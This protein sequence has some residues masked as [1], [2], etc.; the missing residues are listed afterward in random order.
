MAN[1]VRAE[2]DQLSEISG[3]F[4]SESG[5]VARRVDTI[6][7][8]METLEGGD[9]IG[10]GAQA[11][12]REMHSEVL[13]ALQRLV[14]ALAFAAKATQQ[15]SQAMKEAEEESAGIF[16][17]DPYAGDDVVDALRRAGGIAQAEVAGLGGAAQAAASAAASGAGS[18]GGG[19][20]SGA[21]S[22]G[23]SAGGGSSGGGGGSWSGEIGFRQ[24][25]PGPDSAGGR[26]RATG[27]RKR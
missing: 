15:A 26:P 5:Q 20:G 3:T 21:G 2:Y 12:F 6:R 9:W 13:P 22:E 27:R 19:G 24:E 23:G 14:K 1:F 18:S 16:R 11:F 25:K 17:R 7:R 8:L 10:K 4:E